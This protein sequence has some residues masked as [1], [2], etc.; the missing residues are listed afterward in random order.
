[1]GVPTPQDAF[2][3][4][5]LTAEANATAGLACVDVSWSSDDVRHAHLHSDL[6]RRAQVLHGHGQRL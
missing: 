4:S 2:G 5:I 6:C 3:A 1:M